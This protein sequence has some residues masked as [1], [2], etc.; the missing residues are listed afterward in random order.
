MG[1]AIGAIALGM[2]DAGDGTMEAVGVELV[3]VEVVLTEAEDSEA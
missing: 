1:T 2:H 3:G